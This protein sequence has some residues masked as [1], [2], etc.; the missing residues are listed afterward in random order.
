MPQLTID[1][2]Y[3]D[4]DVLETW[5][6]YKITDD[7]VPTRFT[8]RNDTILH[9]AGEGDTWYHLAQKYYNDI[10]ERPSGLWWVI[11]D[12]QPQPIV[13]PTL[14]VRIGNIIYIPSPAFVQGNILPYIGEV[15]Q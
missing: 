11:C 5:D 3:K 9:L 2:R 8:V 13:D 15:Y 7:Y 6:G 10:S 12:F 1:S 14:K 4:L